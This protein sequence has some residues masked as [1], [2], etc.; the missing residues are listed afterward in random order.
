MLH[1]SKERVGKEYFEFGDRTYHILDGAAMVKPI[2][3]ILA[4]RIW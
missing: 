3:P 1:V 4:E 2:V